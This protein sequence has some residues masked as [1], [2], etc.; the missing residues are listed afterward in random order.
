MFV[1]KSR[2]DEIETLMNQLLSGENSEFKRRFIRALASLT[3]K[4]WAV[5]EEKA[6]EIAGRRTEPPEMRFV[7]ETPSYSGWTR[8]ELHAELDRQLD[9]QKEAEASA[10][11]SPAPVSAVG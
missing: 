11:A 5:I 2:E 6:Q 3:E 4:Q 9:A 8:E 7:D 1:K 10:S